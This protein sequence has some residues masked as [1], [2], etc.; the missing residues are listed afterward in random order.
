MPESGTKSEVLCTA[1]Q[2]SGRGGGC[3]GFGGVGTHQHGL[4][5]TADIVTLAALGQR[6][7]G[8]SNN[9]TLYDLG[10]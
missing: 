2:H 1:C 7:V 5:G 3:V 10:C 9:G 8:F 6:Q 4:T